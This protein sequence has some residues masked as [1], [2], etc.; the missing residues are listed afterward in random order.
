MSIRRSHLLNT[1]QSWPIDHANRA[2]VEAL[3]A[4]AYVDEHLEVHIRARPYTHTNTYMVTCEFEF[5]HSKFRQ[6]LE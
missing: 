1:Q 5:T 3:T 4:F 6:D 2:G